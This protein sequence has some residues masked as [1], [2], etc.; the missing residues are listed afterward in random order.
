VQPGRLD[1]IDLP[2]AVALELD[3]QDRAGEGFE[4]LA[5]EVRQRRVAGLA[6]V[7]Q[8]AEIGGVA[9]PSGR[10]LESLLR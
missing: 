10:N 6:E 9:R 4:H 5:R 7:D 1:R 2:D 3:A 8:D